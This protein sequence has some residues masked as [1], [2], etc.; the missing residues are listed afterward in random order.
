MSELDIAKRDLKKYKEKHKDD[1][2]GISCYES[3]LKVIE[4]FDKEMRDSGHSGFSANFTKNIIKSW[5]F[6]KPIFPIE[7]DDF[8]KCDS[9]QKGVE[10]YY[11]EGVFKKVYPDGNV[12]YSDVDRV[13][14]HD[15]YGGKDITWHSGDADRIVEEYVGK[16]TMPY[17]REKIHVYGE[18][19]Y[20]GEDGEDLTEEYPGETNYRYIKYI[21]KGDGT[22]IE[23][24][25]EF[26]E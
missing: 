20:L 1:F 11:F 10:M 24:N 6:E 13:I 9:Y 2:Y 4:A 21:I 15:T 3:A 16:I 12:E 23:V 19:K 17:K 18:D 7:D 8:V 5:L 26:R 25:K 22:R 14:Y